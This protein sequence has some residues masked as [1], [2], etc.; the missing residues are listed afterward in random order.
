[1]VF[2]FGKGGRIRYL[3]G[4]L[5]AREVTQEKVLYS[6]GKRLSETFLDNYEITYLLVGLLHHKADIVV[7]ISVYRTHE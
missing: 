3:I 6:L 1:M 7:R 5:A 4:R 2:D